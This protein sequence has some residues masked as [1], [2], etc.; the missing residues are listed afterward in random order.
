MRDAGFD[1]RL[2]VVPVLSGPDKYKILQ[3]GNERRILKRVIY[4][5][6]CS[7]QSRRRFG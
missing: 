6:M 1:L 3:A 4:A 5:S 7:P 2:E